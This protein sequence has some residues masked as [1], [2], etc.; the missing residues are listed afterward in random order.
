M[1]IKP[2]VAINAGLVTSK[3]R[4]FFI[5][6]FWLFGLLTSRDL[7]PVF[8]T[9]PLF[10]LALFNIGRISSPLFTRDDMFWFCII[11]FFVVGPCQSL[12]NGVFGDSGAVSRVTYT[13]EELIKSAGIVFLSLLAF[14]VFSIRRQG[15]QLNSFVDRKPVVKP[16]ILLAVIVV[17]VVSFI[18]YIYF[19]GGISNVLAARTL[20]SGEG[21]GILAIGFLAMQFMS[22]L[23]IAL[24]ARIRRENGDGHWF[25]AFLGFVFA[26]CMLLVSVNPLNISRFMFVGTWGPVVLGYFGN[27]A[28]YYFVYIILLFGMLV[29]MPVMSITTR[30]GLSAWESFSDSNYSRDL[31]VIKDVDVFDTLTHTIK[32][33]EMNGIM[34]GDNLVAIVLFFVPRQFWPEKPIVGGLVI[35]EDLYRNYGAGTPNLSYYIGGDFYMD[36]GMP[37]V[38]LGFLILGFIWVSI[39][40]MRISILGF[41]VLSLIVVGSIPILLRGP[42]GAIIGYFFC[43]VVAAILFKL[44]FNVAQPHDYLVK[45]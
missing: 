33:V 27:W 16:F 11:V 37:G 23:A 12:S 25:G 36:F 35:G 18:G 30:G 21:V 15:K 5:L 2:R 3:G 44:Y 38:F 10:V 39:Q 26:G 20:K 19:S 13:D 42:V 43:Q 22:T 32:Y 4:V 17:A 41:D 8:L 9:F 1:K 45:R 24:I 34:Y 28:K 7:F 29:A 31:F 40:K 6:V 14:S